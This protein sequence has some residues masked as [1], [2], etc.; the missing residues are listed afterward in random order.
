MMAPCAGSC[1]VTNH[2]PRY[3][4]LNSPRFSPPPHY[5]LLQISWINHSLEYT[6]KTNNNNMSA[7]PKKVAAKPKKPAEHPTYKV[8]I[9][10]AIAALKD[11]TLRAAMAAA[12]ITL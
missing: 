10:A 12:I 11:R 9:A 5:I 1:V 3:P 2:D 8:M 6:N 4:A 7:S